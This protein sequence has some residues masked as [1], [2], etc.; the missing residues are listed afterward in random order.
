MYKT[1]EIIGATNEQMNQFALMVSQSF[2]NS[3]II[4][5]STVVIQNNTI[6]I[7][8]EYNDTEFYAR[9]AAMKVEYKAV[10]A[11]GKALGLVTKFISS[12]DTRPVTQENNPVAYQELVQ[13]MEVIDKKVAE[14]IAHR[15]PIAELPTAKPTDLDLLFEELDRLTFD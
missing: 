2:D 8:Y 5:S 1:L 6:E 9:E 14:F 11:A 3:P 12:G 7:D 10:L 13:K 15:E 4:K